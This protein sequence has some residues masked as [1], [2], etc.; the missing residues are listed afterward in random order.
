[1]SIHQENI[2]VRN[3]YALNNRDAKLHDAEL[4]E[5]KNSQKSEEINPQLFLD[6]STL[7]SITDGSTRR[8][9]QECRR[10]Q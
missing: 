4:T 6:S 10:T 5:L 1:M 8:K 2:S 3:A 9:Y 7:L